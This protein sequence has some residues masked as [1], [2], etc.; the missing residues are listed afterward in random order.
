MKTKHLFQTMSVM[1]IALLTGTLP[2]WAWDHEDTFSD[3]GGENCMFRYNNGT[4]NYTMEADFFHWNGIKKEI[5]ANVKKYEE[6]TL[7]EAIFQ[8]ATK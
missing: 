3:D 1:L 4:H 5:D 7:L 6:T 2:T 8:S